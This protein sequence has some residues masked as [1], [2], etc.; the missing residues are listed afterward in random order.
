MIEITIDYNNDELVIGGNEVESIVKMKVKYP[1]ETLKV[2]YEVI[3]VI[4][5][6]KNVRL[7]K[8]DEDTRT[9]IEEW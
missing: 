3:N 5:K 6:A 8:I 1:S 9:T 7:S 4:F 2:I